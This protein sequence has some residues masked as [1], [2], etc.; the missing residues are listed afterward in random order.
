MQTTY[1]AAVVHEGAEQPPSD[2]GSIASCQTW[3][4]QG[5]AVWGQGS[6]MLQI[7]SFLKL[8]AISPCPVPV[9]TAL[10]SSSFATAGPAYWFLSYLALS[11]LALQMFL[12]SIFHQPQLAC[13]MVREDLKACGGLQIPHLLCLSSQSSE[14]FYWVWRV[15]LFA[16]AFMIIFCLMFY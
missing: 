2:I 10:P 8:T 6:C 7:Q 16:L 12:D 5:K 14:V 4:V 9:N 15:K 1:L 11:Y 13:P 3:M